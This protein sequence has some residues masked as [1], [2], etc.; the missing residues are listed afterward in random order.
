MEAHDPH[1]LTPDG[2]DVPA[3]LERAAR[4]HDP[5]VVLL[6]PELELQLRAAEEYRRA[7]R[8]E[9]TKR[10][11]LSDW[12]HF[13]AYCVAHKFDSLPARP[14]VVRLYISSMAAMPSARTK[15]PLTTRTITRRITTLRLIH[16]LAG[17]ASP[18]EDPF[19]RETWRGIR[20]THGSAA[21]PKTAIT[22]E[23]L[24]KMVV[25]LQ[26]HDD[27]MSVRDR[28]LLLLIFASALR[29]E[30]VATISKEHL[31]FDVLGVRIQVPKSKTNQL[32]KEDYVSIRFG[33][34]PETPDDIDTC[35]V[36]ALQ[37]WLDVAKIEDGS[38]V[39]RQIDRWGKLAPPFKY[40]K[41]G[42]LVPNH[43]AGDTVARL[44][45]KAV[46]RIGI[47]PSNYAGHSMRRGFITHSKKMGKSDETIMRQTKQTYATL[48][49]YKDQ[50][51]LWDEH[52]TDGLGL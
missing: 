45:K 23:M 11:Y 5:S 41:K 40:N 52:P 34:R 21:R 28:A 10:C 27:L 24:Q 17:F 36:R 38:P 26:G 51:Q 3:L 2:I 15:K 44:I 35:P 37:R 18:T 30:N 14:E 25:P 33:K 47:D 50:E 20:A 9:N 31:R 39:F 1:A 46:K 6:S 13:Q 19:V 48:Q 8:N 12:Q 32:G 42:A 49:R 7:A 16:N 43:I 22:L 4:P 29:R